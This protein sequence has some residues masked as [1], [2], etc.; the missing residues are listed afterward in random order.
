MSTVDRFLPTEH[1][2]P[3]QSPLIAKV[4]ELISQAWG[5]PRVIHHNPS[6]NPVSL[7]KKYLPN[8]EAKVTEYVVAEKSDGV[9][10]LLVIGT[11]DHKGLCVMVNRKMHMFEVPVYANSEYFRGSVFDGEMILETTESGQERQ[12]FL[13]FDL[14]SLKGETRRHEHLMK[15]YHEY[16]DVFD[17]EGKDILECDSTKWETFAFEM[18]DTKDKV[19]CLGNR[20]ALQFSPK[21]FV[22]LIHVGSI[23]RSR[24][25][26]KHKSDGLIL[27]RT[28]AGIGT[29]TDPNILKWKEH[30]TIDLVVNAHYTKGRWIYKLSFQDHD[31]LVESTDRTFEINQRACYLQ[32]QSNPVLTLTSQYFAETHKTA[33]SLL[34]ECSCHV[35]TDLTTGRSPPSSSDQP[36]VWCTVIKWRKDKNTPNNVTVVQRTLNNIVDNVTTDELL[37]L[38]TKSMYNIQ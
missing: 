36:I 8:L 11:Y 5:F 2:L 33:F 29:G 35:D 4:E 1:P 6:P 22:Q 18:A 34:G 25:N 3:P 14:V 20:R 27:T 28:T 15:R 21:P 37:H 24:H 32:L 10:Y 9:R 30:H 23:L 12:K 26:L 31:K 38:S 19:V 7:E 13:V 17:L 16:L